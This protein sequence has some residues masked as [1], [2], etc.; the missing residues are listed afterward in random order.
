MSNTALILANNLSH[1]VLAHVEAAK[2]S[3]SHLAT[4]Y[5]VTEVAGQSQA[6]VEATGKVS[7]AIACIRRRGHPRHHANIE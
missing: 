4:V 7:P 6:T 1:N 5:L 2:T 3:L